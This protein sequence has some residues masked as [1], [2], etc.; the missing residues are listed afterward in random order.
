[1]SSSLDV[2]KS[3]S[4]AGRRAIDRLVR[5]GE[6]MLDARTLRKAEKII[7]RIA[8]K[9]GRRESRQPSPP[10]PSVR[11]DDEGGERRK[12]LIGEAADLFYHPLVLLQASGIEPSEVGEELLRRHGLVRPA[13]L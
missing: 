2:V 1:M 10:F 13:H 9:V 12:A 4:R 3:G 8:Q 5:R 11:G 6:T 7:E